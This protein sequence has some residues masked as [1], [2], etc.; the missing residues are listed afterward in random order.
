MVGYVVFYWLV[1]IGEIDFIGHESTHE[2]V[3][4]VS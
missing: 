3:E 1:E 4:N 2:V